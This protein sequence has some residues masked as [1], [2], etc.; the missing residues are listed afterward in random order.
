PET[1]GGGPRPRHRPAQDES[2]D[3]GGPPDRRGGGPDPRRP[4][5]CH[6]R[7]R[8][9]LTGYG[10]AGGVGGTVIRMSYPRART[11]PPN[12]TTTAANNA[13]STPKTS[14]N[15]ASRNPSRVIQIPVS[16][17]PIPFRNFGSG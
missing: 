6:V 10:P 14:T 7:D 15:T 12:M 3:R 4:P 16:I 5:A 11:P 1:S 13:M 8:N 9:G 2:V 17:R